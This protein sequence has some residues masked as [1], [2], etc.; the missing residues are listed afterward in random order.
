MSYYLHS[1][2]EI[3]KLNYSRFNLDHFYK[4]ELEGLRQ[5]LAIESLLKI[6]KNAFYVTLEAVFVLKIFKFL[7]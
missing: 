6:M 7:F 2:F 4:S 3:L 1:P 5:V